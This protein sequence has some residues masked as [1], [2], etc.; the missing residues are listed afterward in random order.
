[1]TNALRRAIVFIMLAL[2]G[3]VAAC[4]GDTSVTAPTPLR[5]AAP[6][7]TTPTA[8]AGGLHPLGGLAGEY[9]LTVAVDSVCT[10]LP[11]ELRTCMYPAAVTLS[12][13]S[14]FGETNFEIFIGGP[15][16]LEGFDR[17]ERFSFEV[18]HDWHFPSRQRDRSTGLR[19]TALGDDILRDRW[20]R[21]HTCGDG[22]L[23]ESH[24]LR[25]P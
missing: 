1:M 9:T 8:P 20:R 19:G 25:S 4:G 6:T 13:Y 23:I 2:A 15:R 21:S 16:F 3:T 7:L 12:A 24:R 10:D 17:A 22:A 11:A 18:D 14:R 5:P